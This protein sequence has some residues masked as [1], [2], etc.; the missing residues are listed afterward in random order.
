MA[1]L[2]ADLYERACHQD[3]A[4]EFASTLETMLPTTCPNLLFGPSL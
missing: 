2:G 4:R 3:E 1:F